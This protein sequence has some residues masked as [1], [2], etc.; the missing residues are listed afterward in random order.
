MTDDACTPMLKQLQTC[1]IIRQ[2]G[3]HKNRTAGGWSRWG[4]YPVQRAPALC[5]VWG[6]VEQV[7][8]EQFLIGM[9]SGEAVDL[10]YH[11]QLAMEVDRIFIQFH[12]GLS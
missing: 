4:A 5:R 7:A 6:R 11:M 10:W 9:S 8:S 2:T 1:S 3:V 12:S